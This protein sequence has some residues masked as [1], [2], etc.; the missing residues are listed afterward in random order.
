VLRIGSS[1]A[2]EAVHDDGPP[3]V[4]LPLDPAGIGDG[5]GTIVALGAGIAAEARRAGID[6]VSLAPA[7]SIPPEPPEPGMV[8]TVRSGL[9]IP[10]DHRL[11][12][13]IADLVPEQRPEDFVAVAY[14]M[15][16]HK[17]LHFLLV[18]EGDLA[19]TVSDIARYF[20]LTNFTLAPQ[21]HGTFELVLAADIVVSTA[22]SDPWPTA[23]NAA[24]ALGRSLVA[25]DVEG[26][27][28]L[29]A[30]WAEDRLSLV[31]PGD[32]AGLAGAVETAIA[33]TRKPRAT[34]KAWKTAQRRG[35]EGLRLMADALRGGSPESKGD[36]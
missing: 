16:H 20:G 22:E 33:G 3:M 35:A 28:E 2:V 24:L 31:Q 10:A 18:G 12:V 4:D 32:V 27:K 8:A 34:K 23:A 36:N 11:A 13:S 25:T 26:R 19:G 29:A 5:A 15:R 9:G 1:A 30:N 14:R 7:P 17:D 21:S 6:V